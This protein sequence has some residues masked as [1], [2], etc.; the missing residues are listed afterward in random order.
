MTATIVPFAKKTSSNLKKKFQNAED[1]TNLNPPTHDD[2]KGFINTLTFLSLQSDT[3]SASVDIIADELNIHVQ[4]HDQNNFIDN[5]G[6]LSATCFEVMAGI[7]YTP[8]NI[9]KM[10]DSLLVAFE[11]LKID[12]YEEE[13]VLILDESDGTPTE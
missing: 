2:L 12:N 9:N 4:H 10:V 7:E 13:I 8:T 3:G 1:G 6:V 5:K 11:R